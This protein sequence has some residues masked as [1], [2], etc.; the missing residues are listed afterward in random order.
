MVNEIIELWKE[1]NVRGLRL[2]KLLWDFS[3][4][5]DTSLADLQQA[6]LDRKL[7]PPDAS[8]ISRHITVWGEWVVRRQHTPEELEGISIERLYILRKTPLADS[9]YYLEKARTLPQKELLALLGDRAPKMHLKLDNSLRGI[10]EETFENV[11]KVLREQTGDPELNMSDTQIMEFLCEMANATSPSLLLVLWRMFLGEAE[12]AEYVQ[13]R[14]R[15]GYG[16]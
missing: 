11:R 1:R 4:T 7:S 9:A 5:S 10:V 15:L 6:F 12:P 3:E 13:G 2:A 8:A 14:K 16:G